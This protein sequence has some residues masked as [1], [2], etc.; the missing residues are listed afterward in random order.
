[1]IFIDLFSLPVIRVGRWLSAQ[2]ARYNIVV[3][4]VNFLIDMPFQ[5]FVE[6]LE[7]WRAF[8]REK[9]EEIH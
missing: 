3:V 9:K 2:W 5:R 1:M 8:L 7:Q 6:F 4:L